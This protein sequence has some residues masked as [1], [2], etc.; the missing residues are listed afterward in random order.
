MFMSERITLTREQ[1]SPVRKTADTLIGGGNFID[2]GTVIVGV[3]IGNPVI[4]GAGVASF[5]VGK[6][7]QNE[8]IR[9]KTIK[10]GAEKYGKYISI[11]KKADVFRGKK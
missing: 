3:A 8:W 9:K 5:A 1:M 7:V 10:P 2:V 11:P 4:A 6:E